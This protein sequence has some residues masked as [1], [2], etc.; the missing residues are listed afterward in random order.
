MRH[1]PRAPHGAAAPPARR[2][3]R[4]RCSRSS[5]SARLLLRLL[6]P[7]PLM[8]GFTLPLA[9][10]VLKAASLAP[11]RLAGL[12]ARDLE[13]RGAR[14]RCWSR[15]W[16]WP[17]GSRSARCAA[18]ARR[19]ST[20][21]PPP[22]AAAA[23]HGA[24]AAAGEHQAEAGPA[25]LRHHPEHPGQGQ[26][27]PLLGPRRPP[28]RAG[29]LLLLVALLL[30]LAVAVA[31]RRPQLL[32]GRAQNLVETVVEKVYDCRSWTSSG[33]R[34]GPRYMPFLGSLFVYILAMN[35]VRHGAALR[36]A[37]LESQR[38]PGAGAHRLRLRA[39]HRRPRAGLPRLA[40]APR[41]RARARR[42]SGRWCR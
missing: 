18:R 29:H 1:R 7:A 37:D 19:R 23:A 4:R 26:R 38:H 32:P 30:V 35:L 41:R 40:R 9:V 16:R 20:R 8:V 42:S 13:P 27:G 10:I 17:P 28:V 22:T 14:P 31:M 3:R 5:A 15:W 21:S 12:G 39:V 24:E 2:W 36:V 6:P 34:Y 25:P 11:A 33:P